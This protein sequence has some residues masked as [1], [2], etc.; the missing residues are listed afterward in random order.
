MAAPSAVA[1]IT[2]RN[3]AATASSS[4]TDKGHTPDQAND[5]DSL[6]RWCANGG[7]LGEWWQVDLQ[8]AADLTGCEIHWEKDGKRYQYVVEGSVDGQIWKTLSDQS[9]S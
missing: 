3:P 5:G 7:D 1:P 8:N 4:E 6:T 2:S 9:A